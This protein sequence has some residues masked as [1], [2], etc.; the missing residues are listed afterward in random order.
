M[1]RKPKTKPPKVVR[2]FVDYIISM[3]GV[4][5]NTANAYESDLIMFLRFM[6]I[7][8]EVYPD[9]TPFNEIPVHD[10]T[11]EFI[12]QIRIEDIH[13]FLAYLQNS[14]SNNNATRARKVSCLRSFFTYLYKKVKLIDNDI[15]ED[16]DKP[17]I[18]PKLP[19]FLNEKEARVLINSVRGRNIIRNQCIIILFLNTG[20]RLSELCSINISAID[21]DK[22]VI[23]GKGNKQREV[24]LNDACLKALASYMN[25]RLSKKYKDAAKDKDALFLSEQKRRISQRAVQDVVKNAIKNAHMNENYSTHK[26]RHTA[27]TLMYRAGADIR[28]IQEILGHSSVATTQVY[29]HVDSDQLRSVVKLNPLNTPESFQKKRGPGR[30]KK[31]L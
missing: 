12:N 14:R 16:L 26:L 30:P 4:S 29:T 9:D 18:E 23:T 2:N 15:V 22:I 20:M 1:K 7:R 31:N 10:I 27:A 3:K 8:E 5:K 11:L 13:A 21:I 19:I 17:K 6:L 24:Y 28:S 25:I